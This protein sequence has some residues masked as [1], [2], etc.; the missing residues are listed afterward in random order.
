M[1]EENPIAEAIKYAAR[2][3][4]TEDAASPMGALEFV[5]STI[6]EG[7]ESIALSLDSIANSLQKFA[8]SV[9]RIADSLDKL[10]NKK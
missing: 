3:L 10:A 7:A 5:G 9:S 2:H 4:G 6:K 1:E 8:D